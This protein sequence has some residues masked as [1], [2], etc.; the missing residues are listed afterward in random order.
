MFLWKSASS[1]CPHR[2]G[3][4]PVPTEGDTLQWVSA[5]LW[6]AL[7]AMCTWGANWIART[8]LQLIYRCVIACRVKMDLAFVPLAIEGLRLREYHQ[9]VF[10]LFTGAG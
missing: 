1:P 8:A 7:D 6:L 9:V 2:G 3:N 4:P 5:Q 10:H